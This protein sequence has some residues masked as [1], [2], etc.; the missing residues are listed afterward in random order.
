MSVNQPLQVCYH[1][2]RLFLYYFNCS[3]I[4]RHVGGGDEKACACVHFREGAGSVK[5]VV[6]DAFVPFIRS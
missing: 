3:L 6:D 5:T 2:I 1:I 4:V